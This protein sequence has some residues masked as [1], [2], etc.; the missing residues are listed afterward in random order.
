MEKEEKAEQKSRSLEAEGEEGYRLGV[1]GPAWD[2]GLKKAMTSGDKVSSSGAPGGSRLLLV[3]LSFPLSVT[4]LSTGFDL[5]FL[6]FILILYI[7][8]D[9]VSGLVL[10]F[11]YVWLFVDSNG[12]YGCPLPVLRFLLALSLCGYGNNCYGIFRGFAF[13]FRFIR[14]G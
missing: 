14:E 10:N 2:W 7:D 1:S 4:S 13:W 8:V 12:K 6:F 5:F 11:V 3:Y 9:L